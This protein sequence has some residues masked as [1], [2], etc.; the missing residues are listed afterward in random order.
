MVRRKPLLQT[1]DGPA[2]RGPF[3]RTVGAL[4]GS[5]GVLLG[6]GYWLRSRRSTH[7]A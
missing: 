1:L 5:L 2:I 3:E 7:R 6:I 4:V